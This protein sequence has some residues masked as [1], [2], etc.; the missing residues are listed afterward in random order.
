MS[1]F[2][3]SVHESPGAKFDLLV[4]LEGIEIRQREEDFADDLGL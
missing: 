4:D 2:F 3:R 1:D